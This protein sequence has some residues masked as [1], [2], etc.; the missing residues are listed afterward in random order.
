[1]PAPGPSRT[2]R[3]ALQ[4]VRDRDEADVQRTCSDLPRLTPSG[5]ALAKHSVTAAYYTGRFDASQF[6]NHL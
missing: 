4:I 5:F 2:V 1:M 3:P 6:R